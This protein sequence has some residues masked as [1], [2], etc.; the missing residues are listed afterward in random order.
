M[1]VIQI[2]DDNIINKIAAGEV[3]ERPASV[4]KELVENSLDAGASRIT[5]A[6]E[7]GGKNLV[8]VTDN[9]NGM[10]RSDLLL[11]VERHATS[12]IRSYNDLVEVRSLGFRGE[13]LASIAAVSRLEIR[14][15]L[16]DAENGHLLSVEDGVIKSVETAPPLQGTQVAIRNLFY[17]TPVRRKFLT[18]DKNELRRVIQTVKRFFLVNPQIAFELLSEGEE[19]YSF[20]AQDIEAR[21]SALYS[22]DINRKLMR[23]EGEEHDITVSGFLGKMT[24]FRKSYGEQ[25]LFVNGRFISNRVI[26]HAV[27]SAYGNMLE[28]GQVPFFLLNLELDPERT[29]V[30][31]HPTKRE[32][33]F[34]NESLVHQVISHMAKEALRKGGANEFVLPESPRRN[35][36]TQP[37]TG[38]VSERSGKWHEKQSNGSASGNI[39]AGDRTVTSRYVELQGEMFGNGE[40][41]G[42]HDAETETGTKLI[43]RLGEGESDQP[44]MW[45]IH[46][47]YILAEVQSGLIIVDQHVAHER[48]L[49]EQALD[50][51]SNRRRDS[52]RVLF[53]VKVRFS[54]EEELAFEEL[55]GMLNG[56]GY[57]FVKMEEH[58][59]AI[60]EVPADLKNGAE[61]KLIHDIIAQYGEY[62]NADQELR[63][64]MAAAFSCKAAIKAGDSLTQA[65]MRFLVDRL[66]ACRYPYSCPH[67][68]PVVMNLT[69]DEL[70]KRFG[71]T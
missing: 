55:A 10:S 71:R 54:T 35:W 62:R 13:A 49:Y 19:I 51:F 37:G 59:W 34:E 47:K 28:R 18:S 30:N 33:K 4:V 53:P 42:R 12:K 39:P 61:E 17:S 64:V 48:I 31:V 5:I 2:L 58:T 52:Q 23:V 25:F 15:C 40:S 60:E 6:V 11:S 16:P 66:F 29:D 41:A 57:A 43:N 14:T 7:A 9:G 67:G 32:I 1:N 69:L 50:A 56:L 22:D 21:L 3:I 45:Q 44:Q 70:D 26:N 46:R 24:T 63:E 65:E 20:P 27:F 38:G 36:D 68:R 8:Q